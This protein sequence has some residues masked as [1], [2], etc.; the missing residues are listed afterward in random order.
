ME[1]SVRAIRDIRS[2]FGTII[3]GP[4]DWP[5]RPV[6]EIFYES[7]V[8]AFRTGSSLVGVIWPSRLRCHL[9]RL[10]PER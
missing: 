1:P 9:K 7:D 6:A 4:Y 10:K 8:S 3:E 2:G 5:V